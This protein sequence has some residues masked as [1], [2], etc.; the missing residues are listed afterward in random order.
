MI[1]SCR[2]DIYFLELK[3]EKFSFRTSPCIRLVITCHILPGR[4]KIL[5]LEKMSA[6]SI[7]V[8]NPYSCSPIH[9][10]A[11]H[12][13]AWEIVSPV[14]LSKA[15]GLFRNTNPCKKRVGYQPRYQPIK[16][17]ILLKHGGGLKDSSGTHMP[18]WIVQP[19]FYH[20]HVN[21]PGHSNPRYEITARLSGPESGIS[22]WTH[23]CLG[24][25]PTWWSPAC[26]QI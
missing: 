10:S 7:L 20:V 8:P 21:H 23:W 11:F 5:V 1:L 3:T 22:S 13:C 26:S 4:F 6:Q 25:Q 14:H 15:T 24:R 16:Q 19:S 17:L 9:A 18:I 12:T 2:K